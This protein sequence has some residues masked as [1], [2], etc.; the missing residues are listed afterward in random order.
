V[1]CPDCKLDLVENWDTN[2]EPEEWAECPNPKCRRRFPIEAL[3]RDYVPVDMDFDMV[4]IHKPRKKR[5]DN[6]T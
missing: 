4:G 5:R 3:R 2:D 6:A 1:K